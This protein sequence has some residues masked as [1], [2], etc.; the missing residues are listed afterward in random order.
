MLDRHRTVINHPPTRGKF[1]LRSR[2][3]HLLAIVTRCHLLLTSP[4]IQDIITTNDM[5]EAR[6][7]K[8]RLHITG[9]CL[10]MMGKIKHDATMEDGVHR[11]HRRQVIGT[12]GMEDHLDRHLVSDSRISGKRERDVAIEGAAAHVH[13]GT[14]HH[15]MENAS[16]S[17]Q[18]MNDIA[19]ASRLRNTTATAA[20]RHI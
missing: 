6:S 7:N 3:Q 1:I 14:V 9:K 12:S 13:H 2:W 10:S 17:R 5:G 15:R 20:L 11:H 8:A 18:G 19:S 16:A 4:T